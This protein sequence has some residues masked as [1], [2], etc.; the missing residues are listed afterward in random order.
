MTRISARCLLRQFALLVCLLVSLPMGGIAIAQDDGKPRELAAKVDGRPIYA[1]Q[2][3]RLIQR[4]LGGR[5]PL[6]GFALTQMRARTLEQLVSRQIILSYLEKNR[7]AASDQDLT[8]ELARIE[9][10]LK[11]QDLTLA[12]Y[13]EQARLLDMDDLRGTLAWQLGW[14]RFLDK[15][16]TEENI[17]KHYDRERAQFDGTRLEVA[18]I[19]LKVEPADDPQALQR[20]LDRA[21]ALREEIVSGKL[22]FAAAARQHSVAPT[23]DKGG[24]IGRISRR[25]P[26]PEQFSAAAYAL[27]KGEISPP[28]ATAFGV[29]LILCQEAHPGQKPLEAVRDEVEADARRYLFEWV[30]SQQRPNSSVEYTGAVP[31]YKSGTA[32]IVG[33]R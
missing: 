15:W 25:E 2:V 24:G 8:L 16:L 18:H 11:E 1:A 3:D 4:T 6:E 27:K 9:K 26:M 19:L 31:H 14:Q 29:H 21:R 12:E 23:A 7:V 5:P 20:T 17:K 22:D 28:V 32:E 10:L 33:G 13:L 30:V